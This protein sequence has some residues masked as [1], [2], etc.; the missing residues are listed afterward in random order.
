MNRD[1]FIV[2]GIQCISIF[3]SNS[4]LE[5]FLWKT[6]KSVGGIEKGK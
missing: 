6:S 4:G 1:T 2:A 5:I 3:Q